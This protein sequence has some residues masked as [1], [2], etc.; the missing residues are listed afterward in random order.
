MF[1]SLIPCTELDAF[2]CEKFRTALFGWAIF[3]NRLGCW[4]YRG[5]GGKV[6]IPILPEKRK[7]VPSP[8]NR[9]LSGCPGPPLRDGHTGV[10]CR[11]PLQRD[12]PGPARIRQVP[13]GA[14]TA[15]ATPHVLVLRA[16]GANCDA[17]TQFAFER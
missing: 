14:G 12:Y 8:T 13:N 10:G 2:P 1:G 11:E 9:C 16:P 5:D 7:K 4:K 15:M 6:S 3:P 17:E